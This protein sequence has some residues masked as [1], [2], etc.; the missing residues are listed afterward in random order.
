MNEHGRAGGTAHDSQ[1]PV[2]G[3]LHG[4]LH[5]IE[6][7]TW[8]AAD[9]NGFRN[10]LRTSLTAGIVDVLPTVLNLLGL[11]PPGRIDG[12]ILSEALADHGDTLPP[13]TTRR[14]YTAEGAAGWRAHLAV[15]RVGTTP[16]LD[17][18]WTD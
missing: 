1:L 5:A 10:R 14:T 11:A 12:R 8:L 9:G 6:L 16:Y 7:R 17:R 18:A 3:G 13:E 2:G 15:T 4:G